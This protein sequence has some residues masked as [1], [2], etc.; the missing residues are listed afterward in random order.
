MPIMTTQQSGTLEMEIIHLQE[1]MIFLV[2]WRWFDL[3]DMLKELQYREVVLFIHTK[4]G[5]VL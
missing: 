5:T 2:G 1:E 4:G 3:N